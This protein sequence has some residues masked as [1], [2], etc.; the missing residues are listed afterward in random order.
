MYLY[1]RLWSYW[2]IRRLHWWVHVAHQEM[3]LLLGLC[4]PQ[5]NDICSCD[6][7]PTSIS[8]TNQIC[9]S[10]SGPTQHL[11]LTLTQYLLRIKAQ[12]NCRGS[13]CE[14]TITSDNMYKQN[15]FIV[16]CYLNPLNLYIV[17]SLYKHYLPRE[18]LTLITDL[19]LKYK[20]CCLLSFCW[21]TVLAFV[22]YCVMLWTMNEL[23]I[24]LAL[25][26]AAANWERTVK[27]FVLHM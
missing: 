9:D 25:L 24:F 19:L 4:V 27:E 23:L 6:I 7:C 16:S 1:G 2:N 15:R 13:R 12:S 20:P 8:R 21:L 10:N 26:H 5:M 17:G 14:I 3:L 11:N 22:Q 18:G